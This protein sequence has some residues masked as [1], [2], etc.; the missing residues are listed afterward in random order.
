M[1][2]EV[3]KFEDIKDDVDFTQKLLAEEC[4]LVL[5]GTIFQIPNYVRLVRPPNP[6]M[7]DGMMVK[8]LGHLTNFDEDLVAHSAHVW[9]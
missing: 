2:I 6:F 9:W 3:E 4:V 8:P 5:P 1:G 7:P